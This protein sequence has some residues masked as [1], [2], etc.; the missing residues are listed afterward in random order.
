M[1]ISM[2]TKIAIIILALGLTFSAKAQYV[3]IP[4]ANFV[5]YLQA[6]FPLCMSGNQ[7]DT[8]CVAGHTYLNISNKNISDL[9]GLQ[10]WHNLVTLDCSWNQLSSLPL[11]PNSLQILTCYHNQLTNLPILPY[12]LT[13][14][15]CRYNQLTGLPALP[16]AL[17]TLTCDNNL[18]SILPS[19]NNTLQTL[20]CGYN[21]L[22]IL[23]SLNNTLQSL[24]CDHNQ[25]TSLP[26]LPNSLSWLLCGF[27]TLTSLPSIPN[28]L[29]HLD[30]RSNLLTNLPSLPNSLSY[31]DC[32]SNLLTNIIVFPSS[33]T[34]LNCNSN[35]L[36]SLPPLPTQLQTMSC[37]FNYGIA[38]LPS[39][40]NSL[41]G[42]SCTANQLTSLPAL[43]NSLLS[44]DCGANQL[45]NLPT[46]PN[47]LTSLV[48]NYNQL[49]GL[50]ALPSALTKLMCNYNS[51]SCFP[52]LPSSLTIQNSSYFNIL[53]N[54]FH[55][56]PNYVLAMDSTTLAFPICISG[57][58]INNPNNCANAQGIIGYSYN[59]INSDC[60][61]TGA[62]HILYNVPIELYDNNS[63]LIL[64]TY[65]LTNG[66]YDFLEPT[67]TYFVK[68]DTT[69][70][71]FK[72]QCANPGIDST[73][74]LTISNPLMQ[75]VNFA[76]DC[77]PGFDIGA[78]SVCHFGGA[79]RPGQ[80]HSL[81]FVLGDISNWY[82]LHCSSGV[83]GQVVIIVTGPVTYVSP[84]LG[85]LTPSVAGNV[86]T[87]NVADFGATN[88]MASFGLIMFTNTGAQ[89]GDQIFVN[90]S[91]TPTAGDN[92]ASNNTF[93][94]C[95]IV[96][97]SFDPNFKE[98]YPEQV[99]PGYNDYFYYTIHFQNTGSAPAINIQLQDTLDANLDLN[100]FQVVNY[101]HYNTTMLT[102]NKL[103]FNFPNIQLADSTTDF[104]GSQGYVQ[105]RIKPLANLP[106]GT[107]IHN[108]A[109]IY[110]DYNAPVVTNT[111]TNEFMLSINTSEIR[112]PKSE[113]SIYPN[114]STGKFV[115]K[116]SEGTDVSKLSIEVTNV[117][118]EIIL[119]SKIQHVTSDIDLSNQP[120]G[121]Y[122]IRVTG[123]EQ[124]MNE[125][126]VKQ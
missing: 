35:Q 70:M 120:K 91:I 31:L 56:L 69:G 24:S 99:Q 54:P 111:T 27:N 2:K 39:L 45:T 12:N 122:F 62:D 47:F 61:K 46:L 23:P 117:L 102:G 89:N 108:K 22:S 34:Y 82:N 74:I 11:L 53:V 73:V 25:L 37:S 71:P 21:Q 114:P 79:I 96:S 32:A 63:N 110:F 95:Y 64:L 43:P 6:N 109:S 55:C 92:N 51:I 41:T 33:L 86:F 16:S 75:N 40:P 67:G 104:N 81:K 52:N 49:T 77:K 26:V 93:N 125:R 48:C 65:T 14:L 123:G 103:S 84:T 119:Q 7:M 112:N 97:N 78:Q 115:V 68:T 50:P 121:V 60:I 29:T 76:L 106:A 57:D 58:T 87:Y 44:L 66:V 36:T 42:L 94:Y 17:Q 28:S 3:T 13:L 18:L 100:T 80:S 85:A 15:N 10:Y 113:M 88:V 19:L 59:D 90:V 72:E 101:S 98:T 4:D 124:A 38:T 116:L 107:Q 8:T 105:Y 126:V 30:F 5:A 83:S 9:T 1:P 118:G 20:T